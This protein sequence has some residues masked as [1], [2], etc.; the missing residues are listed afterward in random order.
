MEYF[1]FLL[2][3]KI[4]LKLSFLPVGSSQLL[5]AVG[6]FLIVF[7]LLSYHFTNFFTAAFFAGSN[8][9]LGAVHLTGWAGMSSSYSTSV[10]R[11]AVI[12]ILSWGNIS[13]NLLGVDSCRN[14]HLVANVLLFFFRCCLNS[15]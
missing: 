14:G 9:D 11:L 12:S 13:L 2:H 1:C 3:M 5:A 8:S 10:T 15:I 7:C 6:N 4:V